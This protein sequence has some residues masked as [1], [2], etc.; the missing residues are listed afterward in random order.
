[1]SKINDTGHAKNVANFE[2]LIAYLTGYGAVYNPSNAN[3][4][5]SRLNEKA[6]A[7]LVITQQVHDLAARNSNAIAARD[8]AFSPLKNWLPEL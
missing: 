5:L 2:T 7:A 6:A 8:L 3:I 4:Q 1:M